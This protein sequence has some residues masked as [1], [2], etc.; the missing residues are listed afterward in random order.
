MLDQIDATMKAMR[1]I[2]TL[3]KMDPNARLESEAII[4]TYKSALGME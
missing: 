1:A 2:I 4:E 3:M